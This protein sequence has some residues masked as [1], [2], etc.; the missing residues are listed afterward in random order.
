MMNYFFL[1]FGGLFNAQPSTQRAGFGDVDA[2]ANTTNS[3]LDSP[4]LTAIA[5]GLLGLDRLC[6]S[7]L[8]EAFSHID[9]IRHSIRTTHPRQ[10]YED[11]EPQIELISQ[12]GSDETQYS[13][14]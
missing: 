1:A 4:T 11:C 10:K 14:N 8:K 3:V 7:L 12:V 13:K 9:A 5:I 2:P 6:R